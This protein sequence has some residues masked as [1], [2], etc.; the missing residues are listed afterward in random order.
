MK[1]GQGQQARDAHFLAT[2]KVFEAKMK[3]G[4]VAGR[5]M[6]PANKNALPMSPAFRAL[7]CETDVI[8]EA[9][10][11]MAAIAC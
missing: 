10:Q 2:Q 6:V 9:R 11:H 7:V 5:N 3:A 1:D 8:A 4:K